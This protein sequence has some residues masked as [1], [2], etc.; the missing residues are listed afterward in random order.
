[1][2]T[3]GLLGCGSLMIPEFCLIASIGYALLYQ[4]YFCEKLVKFR[5]NR[6]LPLSYNFK[7]VNDLFLVGCL[8]LLGFGAVS[9]S[10]KAIQKMKSP[11][12]LTIKKQ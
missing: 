9:K 1:M 8:P 6:Q 7:P 2:V 4:W 11:K 5:F 10:I 12:S 3:F